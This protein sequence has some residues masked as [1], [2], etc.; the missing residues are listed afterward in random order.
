VGRGDAWEFLVIEIYAFA[1][2]WMFIAFT[3]LSTGIFTML[4]LLLLFKLADRVLGRFLH[5]AAFW[6]V[7]QEAC[8]QGRRLTWVD[9]AQRAQ[10]RLDG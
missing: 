5:A 3:V 8:R 6:Q 4:L 2:R 9:R 10:E 1:M 7:L